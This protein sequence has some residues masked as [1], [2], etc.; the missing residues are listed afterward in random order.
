MEADKQS[1]P[2]AYLTQPTRLPSTN[3]LENPGQQVFPAGSQAS[4]SVIGLDEH[5][6][7]LQ[8]DL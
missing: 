3:W 2:R 1:R 8:T 5:D 7:D 6:V 4:S